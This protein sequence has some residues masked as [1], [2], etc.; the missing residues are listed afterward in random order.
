MKDHLVLIVQTDKTNLVLICYLY[1]V[2]SSMR[3]T[4]RINFVFIKL[5][6]CSRLKDTLYR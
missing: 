3:F 2:F 4:H 5:F 1:V 6:K